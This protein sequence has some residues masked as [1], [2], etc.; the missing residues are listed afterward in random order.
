MRMAH[1]ER[2][3]IKI[4]LF[5]FLVT[6]LIVGCSRSSPVIAPSPAFVVSGVPS[7]VYERVLPSV[8]ARL[9]SG[10]KVLRTDD[11]GI[12]MMR[13]SL[14]ASDRSVRLVDVLLKQTEGLRTEVSVH[15]KKFSFIF[16]NSRDEVDLSV[17]NQILEL[18]KK[19]A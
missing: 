1:P 18:V 4:G 5:A 8:K 6:F 2:S 10:A 7:A 17:E 11:P 16:G 15:A 3:A 13:F 9:R 14:S 12:V 19:N